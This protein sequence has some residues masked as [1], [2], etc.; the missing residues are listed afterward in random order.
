MEVD[1]E[2]LVPGTICLGKGVIQWQL[3]EQERLPRCS[4]G[5]FHRGHG[6][7]SRDMPD[8][9]EQ[10][11]LLISSRGTGVGARFC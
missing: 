4:T 1:A 7:V 2:F 8:N 5:S 9:R 6:V 3:S 10:Y 11:V